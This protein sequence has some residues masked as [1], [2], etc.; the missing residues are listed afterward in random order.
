MAASRGE[1]AASRGEMAASRGEMVASR[2]EMA[3]SR[4]EMVASRGE[5]AASR[6]EMDASRGEMVVSSRRDGACGRAVWTRYVAM[7]PRDPRAIVTGAGSGL[8]AALCDLLAA[9]GARIV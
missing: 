7:I 3:A 5:M 8:G 1:M 2:G 9:R 4:G 6:G